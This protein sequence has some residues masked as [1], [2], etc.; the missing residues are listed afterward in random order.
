[1]F[2][3]AWRKESAKHDGEID[4]LKSD[5]VELNEIAEQV[6]DLTELNNLITAV[7]D[8]IDAY[9]AT[10]TG[11]LYFD[12]LTLGQRAADADLNTH[13]SITINTTRIIDAG[14]ITHPYNG[15][16]FE[17]Y[18]FQ[19]W[20]EVW[21]GNKGWIRASIANQKG[22]YCVFNETTN[23]IEIST[24]K[25]HIAGASNSPAAPNSKNVKTAPC[26]LGIQF[27]SRRATT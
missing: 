16:G 11:A 9:D 23:E 18:N 4:Q 14:Y 19:V 25:K 27:Y 3:K 17:N 20:M 13:S 2:S 12:Y 22:I 15:D 8:R 7:S 24:G 10:P 5:L 26:R 21:G 1:M 6:S